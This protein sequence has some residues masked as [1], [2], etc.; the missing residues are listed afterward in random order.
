MAFY[1]SRC[2]EALRD[3]ARDVWD[4]LSHVDRESL[5]LRV[6]D[7]ERLT[8]RELFSLINGELGYP[9]LIDT[10]GRRVHGNPVA[11]YE[12]NVRDLVRTMFGAGQIERDA[13]MFQNKLRYRYSL[14]RAPEGPIT[15]LERAYHEGS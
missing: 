11:A 9:D 3:E 15:G 8:I 10:S 7:G 1:C 13:E 4:S 6:L 14:K 5:L 2:G 12:G